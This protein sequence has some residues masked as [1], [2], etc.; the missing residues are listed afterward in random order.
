[1]MY[2]FTGTSRGITSNQ[3]LILQE[4]FI[5]F[6]SLH[7]GD[8]IGADAMAHEIALVAKLMVSIHP[9]TDMS[10]RAFCKGAHLIY[11]AKP[12]LERNMDIAAAGIN[13]LIATP[14]NF[15]EVTRSGTW[16]TIR[17]AR[18]LNRKITIIFPD[19]TI[20]EE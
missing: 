11:P 10:K 6:D 7:H 9:P 20:R 3:N 14:G 19:G 13:G 12:Y 2:G 4:L 5:N 15:H 1:M 18:K 17:Y 16:S 8:C